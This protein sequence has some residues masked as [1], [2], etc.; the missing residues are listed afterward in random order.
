MRLLIVILALNA[1]VF[2]QEP[3]PDG[4]DPSKHEQCIPNYYEGL[5]PK[6]M[7]RLV[8]KPTDSTDMSTFPSLEHTVNISG[9]VD[10]VVPIVT[11][12]MLGDID[13]N[14]CVEYEINGEIHC[15]Y[16]IVGYLDPSSNRQE[17]VR[18]V[19]LRNF[20]AY[21]ETE[22]P[23]T[24]ALDSSW[25]YYPKKIE[26]KVGDSL[27]IKGYSALFN[28][29]KKEVCTYFPS[30][31]VVGEY[32]VN[33]TEDILSTPRS[34]VLNVEKPKIHNRDAGGRCVNDKKRNVIRY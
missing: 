16:S 9:I 2:A 4:R 19:L 5:N 31:V 3:I 25:I 10:S 12:S 6:G 34:R 24:K 21:F 28:N 22:S 26:L 29:T 7:Q 14:S 17:E 33:P 27:Y 1:L 20:K 30:A 18:H 23:M 8:D 15:H 11:D 13:L 32:F